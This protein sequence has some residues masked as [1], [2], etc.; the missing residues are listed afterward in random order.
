M[1]RLR[2]VI[3][4]LVIY[5]GVLLVLGTMIFTEASTQQTIFVLLGLLLLQLGVWQVASRL[6]PSARRNHLL[7]EE[8]NQFVNQV[9]EMYRLANANEASAFETAV[10]KLRDRTEGVIGAARR[11]LPSSPA[12]APVRP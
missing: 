12:S 11:D 3:D 9:R 10:D 8:V 1:Q 7:R 2:D 4:R 6:L 5:S